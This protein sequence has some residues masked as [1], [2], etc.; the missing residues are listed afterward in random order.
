MY[1]RNQG[2]KQRDLQD[3]INQPK[4]LDDLY[5]R[6][7]EHAAHRASVTFVSPTTLMHLIK[8]NESFLRLLKLVEEHWEHAQA[9]QGTGYSDRDLVLWAHALRWHDR[10]SP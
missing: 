3:R 6:A 1:L 2:F 10:P 4:T 7:R 9:T 8:V 5:E